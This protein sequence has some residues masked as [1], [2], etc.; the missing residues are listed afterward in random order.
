MGI[1]WR[2]GKGYNGRGQQLGHY[3]IGIEMQ[4][5]MSD[6]DRGLDTLIHELAH[7]F[8]HWETGGEGHGKDWQNWYT[9]LK[10]I[11]EE[12]NEY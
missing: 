2:H 6:N 4:R 9:H 8:V 11:H 3:V 5:A 10:V 7:V 1:C 12:T